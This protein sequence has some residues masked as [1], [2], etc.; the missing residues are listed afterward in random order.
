[1][2]I[3]SAAVEGKAETAGEVLRFISIHKMFQF[4]CDASIKTE[5]IQARL[6]MRSSDIHTVLRILVA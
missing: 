4:D 6:L 1:M 5:T 2:K 3:V